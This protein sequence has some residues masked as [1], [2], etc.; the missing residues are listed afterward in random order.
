MLCQLSNVNKGE[1]I[2]VLSLIGQPEDTNCYDTCNANGHGKNI[3]IREVVT[4]VK[5]RTLTE[6]E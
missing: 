6:T 3:D 4:F 2:Q 5:S 1:N